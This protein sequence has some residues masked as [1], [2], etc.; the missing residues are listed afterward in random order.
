MIGDCNPTQV[1]DQEYQTCDPFSASMN[2]EQEIIGNSFTFFDTEQIGY[3]QTCEH[4]AI[5]ENQEL[6]LTNIDQGFQNL[7]SF[8]D[9][10]ILNDLCFNF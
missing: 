3:D 9:F 2:Q 5:Y 1:L 10:N 8:N 4:T 7:G 6:I